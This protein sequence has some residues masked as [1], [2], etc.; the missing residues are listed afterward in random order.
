VKAFTSIRD[1][2]AKLAA[3]LPVA[4]GA[5]AKTSEEMIREVA[6]MVADDD[7]REAALAA[8]PAAEQAV[9]RTKA[10]LEFLRG[11]E[12]DTAEDRAEWAAMHQEAVRVLADPFTRG[13]FLFF[14]ASSRELRATRQPRTPRPRYSGKG[15][16]AVRIEALRGGWTS[17]HAKCRRF[18][19]R[20]RTRA[21]RRTLGVHRSAAR[22]TGPRLHDPGLHPCCGRSRGAQRLPDVDRCYRR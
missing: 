7:E 22:G 5:P 19:Q 14:A 9:A 13:W 21:E 3:A 4:N 15:G 11:L 12:Q 2:L 1:R 20:R 6:Q 10:R 8:L 18:F 17:S 16:A